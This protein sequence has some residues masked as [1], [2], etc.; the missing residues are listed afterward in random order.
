VPALDGVVLPRRPRHGARAFRLALPRLLRAHGA[1]VLVSPWSA[2]PRAD[3]PVVVTVH[4]IPFAR[5]GPLE[6]R[7]RTWRHRR[8]LARDAAEAARILVPSEATRADVLALHPGAAPRLRLVPNAFDPAPWASVGAPRDAGA[9][10]GVLAIGTGPRGYGPHKKGLDVLAAALARPR[11]AGV[12]A[13]VLGE[14]GVRVPGLA[15]ERAPADEDVRRA[16]GRAAVLVHA[17]RS[18]GFGY[19]VLEAFAAGV[20]VVATAA[21]ALPEVCGDA[22]L[23]VAPEDPDA[24]AAAIRRV[25]DEPALAADLVRR[26]LARAEAFLPSRAAR[27][28]LGALDGLGAAR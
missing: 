21:G 3:I 8:W 1:T 13:R 18:E 27:A 5:H 4:E 10:R 9:P 7:W 14:P 20:P 19:P 6:G 17:A 22:A 28:L 16:L 23:L 12:E 24:L 25:L 2:F 26:G 15:I 11:L